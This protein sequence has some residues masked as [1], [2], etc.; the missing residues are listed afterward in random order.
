LIVTLPPATIFISADVTRATQVF[1][2]ILNNAAKFTERGGRIEVTVTK[3]ED[4][5]LVSV[6]DNG[7]GIS[8]ELLPQVFE[9]FTQAN[10]S[11]GRRSSG[12]G[13]GLALVRGLVELHGGNV[14]A[15]SAGAGKGSEFLVHW[16]ICA[17]SLD[18]A[19]SVQQRPAAGAVHQRILVIDDNRDAAGS[20]AAVLALKGNETRTAYD[21]LEGLR[22]AADFRPDIILLDIGMPGLDGIETARRI[23]QQAWGKDITLLAL[24]GWGQEKD[25][26]ESVG[27]GIN[28]HL[29]KPVDIGELD[30]LLAASLR[31]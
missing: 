7:I 13:I 8:Q 6:R 11:T 18:N 26:R 20:L 12:L 1:A 10:H 24:S 30:R 17:G 23:R 2:N 25:K 3:E 5:V 14:E 16:P 22:A 15:H 9:M 28:H 4:Q 27:A 21:G 29:V 19:E 31:R